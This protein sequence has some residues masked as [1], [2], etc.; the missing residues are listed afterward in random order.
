VQKYLFLFVVCGVLFSSC[1]KEPDSQQFVDISDVFEISLNQ[2][3]G[4]FRKPIVELTILEPQDCDEVTVSS[5]LLETSKDIILE[6]S[7]ISK[8][9]N[10][11]SSSQII[12]KQHPLNSGVGD[13]N[14]SVTLAD[15]E[16]NTGNMR[17]T[18]EAVTVQFDALSG[19]SAGELDL[20]MI[21][22]G[23]MWGYIITDNPAIDVTEI[24]AQ[25]FN[26]VPEFEVNPIYTPGHYGLFRI[27]DDQTIA[28]KDI[29]SPD[30]KFY[31][32]YGMTSWEVLEQNV[33][34]VLNTVGAD[35]IT[36]YIV[37]ELGDILG[38]G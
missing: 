13:F 33:S 5:T 31:A 20:R 18:E 29:E 21:N 1:L 10:C 35:K 8:P 7:S 15:F 6:I 32:N 30:L 17:I 25:L 14:F 11:N 16:A 26:T 2:E 3:L 27:L 23:F 4:E 34:E 28:I 37:N 24:K 36:I 9:V 38:N 19:I 12:R 22:D